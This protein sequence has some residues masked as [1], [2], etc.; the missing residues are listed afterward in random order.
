M[1]TRQITA[2]PA[3]GILNAPSSA[4]QVFAQLLAT[5]L[6]AAIAVPGTKR[7]E[8]R[9]FNIRATGVC[10]TSGAAVTVQ[11]FLAAGSSL[12]Q[13]QNT[14]IAQT[15]ATT[16]AQTSCPW[17]IEAALTF[18]SISGKLT[19][20]F[21]SNVNNQVGALTALPT[22]ITGLNGS[23]DPVFSVVCGLTFSTASAQ[24]TAT[25]TEFVLEG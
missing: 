25:L 17:T 24:N 23:N 10:T 20:Q 6:A 13:A 15:A 1:S 7:L 22:V 2:A 3:A 12:T 5:N 11:P 19:G 18:D 4:A 14:V 9:K 8:G 21:T 16:V